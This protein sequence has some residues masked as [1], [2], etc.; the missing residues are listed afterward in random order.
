MFLGQYAKIRNIELAVHDMVWSPCISLGGWVVHYTVDDILSFLLF[1]LEMSDDVHTD[2][3]LQC[4]DVRVHF[5]VT[6]SGHVGRRQKFLSFFFR[7]RSPTDR[8]TAAT[9]WLVNLSCLSTD[10]HSDRSIVHIH[11]T[12]FTE[13]FC[14][15][16]PNIY[17]NNIMGIVQISRKRFADYFLQESLFCFV[18]WLPISDLRLQVLSVHFTLQ[19]GVNESCMLITCPRGVLQCNSYFVIFVRSH[20]KWRWAA[21]DNR[22][23]AFERIILK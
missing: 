12:K 10:S 2:D 7:D 21:K 6:V 13:I 8:W 19:Y 9:H 11:V 22:N 23:S 16:S 14:T 17:D 4:R 3:V 1:G 15:Y 5:D 18:L 20:T